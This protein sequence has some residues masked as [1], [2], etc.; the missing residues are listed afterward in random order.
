MVLALDDNDSF[1][2][3][4]TGVPRNL[5]D[6]RMQM[7]W[8]GTVKEAGEE[9]IEVWRPESKHLGPQIFHRQPPGPTPTVRWMKDGTIDAAC[10]GSK[11]RWNGIV[12]GIR[13]GHQTFM[14]LEKV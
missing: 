4:F 3:C 13:M 6:E 11:L 9:S 8:A 14:L 2:G 5:F 12:V 10:A 7:S 1:G